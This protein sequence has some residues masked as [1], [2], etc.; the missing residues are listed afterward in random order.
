MLLCWPHPSALVAYNGGT[1]VGHSPVKTLFLS[2][3][4]FL[5]P[6][7]P[8]DA[9]FLLAKSQL[10]GGHTEYLVLCGIGFP[11]LILLRGAVRNRQLYILRKLQK[12]HLFQVLNFFYN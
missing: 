5:V 2:L 1:N 12:L 11:S 7:T 4:L 6:I 8:R 10:I 3:I 9:T